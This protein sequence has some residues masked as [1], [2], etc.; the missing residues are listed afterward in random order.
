MKSAIA[1]AAR[2]A[3]RARHAMRRGE[4]APAAPQAEVGYHLHPTVARA[5]EATTFHDRPTADDGRPRVMVSVPGSQPFIAQEGRVTA[6]AI[7]ARFPKEITSPTQADVA[8]RFLND[9]QRERVRDRR[10]AVKRSAGFA[11]SWSDLA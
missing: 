11:G 5:L 8:A 7:R 4:D 1:I 3:A 6:D 10:R 2:V 9:V